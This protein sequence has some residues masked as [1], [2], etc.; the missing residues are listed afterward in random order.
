MS[1]ISS[2]GDI[3]VTGQRYVLDLG[4]DEPL[5]VNT[6]IEDLAS[7][8]IIP[9]INDGECRIKR[10]KKP[11]ENETKK[12]SSLA[13][14]IREITQTIKAETDCT[15]LQQKIKTALNGLNEDIKSG[16][17]EVEKKLDE[18]LPV[19]KLPL[20]PFKIPKWLKKFA[21]GR[22]LPD[23]DATIDLMKRIVEVVTALNE[24]IEVIKELEPRLEA[25]AISTRDMFKRDIENA[26][27]QTLEDIQKDIEKSIA[28]AICKGLNDAKISA[29]DIDNVL[30]GVSVVANLVD[31]FDVFKQEVDQ[32]LG[33]SLTKIGQ[34]QALIQDITGIPPVID[35]T[36]IDTFVE[37]ANSPAYEQYRQDAQALLQQP[38]PVN[39]VPPVV[40]GN[41]AVGSLLTCSN[42]TWTA[43]GVVNNYPLTF[44]WMRQNVEIYGANTFQYTTTPFDSGQEVYCKVIAD[45]QL[46]VEEA[47]SNVILVAGSGYMG[48]VGP[49]G[50]Q[51]PAGA[52]GAQ[53]AA[54][55]QGATGSPGPQG[56]QGSTGAQGAI[57]P[58]GAQGATGSPGPQGVQGDIGPTG[59]QGSLGPQ[60]PQGVQGSIGPQG[61]QGP[62][63]VQGAIGQF[64]GTVTGSLLFDSIL[65]KNTATL[66]TTSVSTVS[67]LEFPINTYRSGSFFIQAVSGSD[68]H[69]T[70]L[71]MTSNTTTAVATEYET[72][73]TGA[74]LFTVEID[75]SGGNTRI[76]ITPASATSTTFKSSYELITT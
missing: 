46:A 29:N 49:Q 9:S 36:S 64:S 2:N 1:E 39:S 51:G 11:D 16:L 26:I 52:T 48:S 63:G 60:G 72:L 38:D 58:T 66:T 61:P 75:V 44:Q 13:A 10:D 18:I 21:L 74:S 42:G 30:T 69:V 71:T 73:V 15:A 62:Q 45:A 3:V 57:G 24:L 43:N 8:Y 23:L 28:N 12:G 35:T 14:D 56:P 32:A 5:A 27:D 7:L 53:G 59:A 37:T 68:A 50:P 4:P 6:Q 19:I 34:N 41:T 25:C 76:R 55:A 47:I 33:T 67:L 54:G 17:K 31:S 20:N 40:T 65:L 22:I 70:R